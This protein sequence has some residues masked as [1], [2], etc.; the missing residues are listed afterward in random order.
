MARELLTCEAEKHL[1]A[2]WRILQSLIRG[3]RID[4]PP[5][6]NAS[7]H[8]VWSAV[9]LRQAREALKTYRRRKYTPRTRPAARGVSDSGSARN[10][11]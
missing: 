11:V 3:R 7:G 5:R 8:Y 4:P 9:N 1:G 2:P 10:G 6:K